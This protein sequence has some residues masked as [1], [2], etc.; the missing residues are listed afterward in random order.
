M[1]SLP[2]WR[3]YHGW[4]AQ[5]GKHSRCRQAR[6]HLLAAGQEAVP[7]IKRG[8]CHQEPM[9]RRQCVNLLD[10]LLDDGAVQALV[11]AIDDPDDQVAARALHALACD[12]CKQGECR[13]AEDLWVPRALELLS[14]ARIDLRAG[15]IDALGKVAVRLPEVAAA[16]ARSAAKDPDKGLRGQARRFVPTGV[17]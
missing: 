13:P 7:A 1:A 11:E 16:L 14:S 12:R 8:L 17:P 2:A 15:A 6:L 5:L 3:D 4:V 9:V 10:H